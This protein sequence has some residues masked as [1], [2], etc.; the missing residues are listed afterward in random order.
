MNF[1]FLPPLA[2]TSNPTVAGFFERPPPLEGSRGN[3]GGKEAKEA[4][5]NSLKQANR[6]LLMAREQGRFLFYSFKNNFQVQILARYNCCVERS[7]CAA[8][9]TGWLGGGGGGE[10]DT[11]GLH[12]RR[13][14]D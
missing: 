13:A 9:G 1:P 7:A 8:E 5:T 11:A 14:S 2:L 3:P 6:G 4:R 12:C 10:G